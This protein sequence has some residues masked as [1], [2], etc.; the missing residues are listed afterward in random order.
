MQPKL[1][2]SDEPARL[3]FVGEARAKKGLALLLVAYRAVAAQ[4]AAELVLVGGVRDGDDAAM[5]TLFQRHYPD[6]RLRIIAWV[7]QNALREYYRQCTL[8]LLP[9]LHDGLPNALLEGMACGC[10]VIGSAVGGMTDV[11]EDGVNGCLVPPGDADALAEAIVRLLDAPERRE[12]LGT[13]A[14][15]TVVRKYTLE[16]EHER[17]REVYCAAVQSTG[18]NAHLV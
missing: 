12:E 9:S 8:L 14:R 1:W 18:G 17:Y 7:G 5:I 6:L 11:V 10:A 16:R 3:L 4:R 15:E 2:P 13:K